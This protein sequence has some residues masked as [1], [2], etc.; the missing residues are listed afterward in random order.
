MVITYLND[1]YNIS[2]CNTKVEQNVE[3]F[4][5]SIIISLL[6]FQFWLFSNKF[7]KLNDLY[8]FKYFSNKSRDSKIN[9]KLNHMNSFTSEF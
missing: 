4:I 1:T 7:I 2:L 3:L 6:L 9:L 5:S 8:Y